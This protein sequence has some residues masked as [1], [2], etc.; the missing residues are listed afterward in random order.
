MMR[1]LLA[2]LPALLLA[3]PA[4]ARGPMLLQEEVRCVI[5]R[6]G[7]TSWTRCRVVPRQRGW[8][9]DAAP[10]APLPIPDLGTPLDPRTELPEA[11]PGLPDADPEIPP[12][13][14][15]QTELPDADP[16]IP[17]PFQR[18]GLPE[19]LPEA[20]LDDRQEPSPP[21]R[22]PSTSGLGAEEARVVELL[23]QERAS[24]G[25]GPLTV[26][27][28]AVAVARAHSQDMCQRHFFDHV[29][30]EGKQPWDR[31]R[32]AGARFT[33]A[34]ENIA[35]GYT[36]AQAV[37]QGWLASPGHRANR[38]KPTYTRTGVGLYHCGN[39]PFWTEVFMK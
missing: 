30:P 39:V 15:P 17:P 1:M 19:R 23:N 36:T 3:L 11:D 22:T 32:A 12:P 10:D 35:V 25:L 7:D 2:T 6:R 38:L 14:D 13:L 33:A 21:A 20:D 37:H 34:G 31:L 18:D 29:S 16:E 4:S 26:D 8:I 9:P 5:V 27:P 24:R 28:V